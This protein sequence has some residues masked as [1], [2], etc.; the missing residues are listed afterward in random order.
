MKYKKQIATGALALSLLVGGSSVFAATPQDLGIKNSQP[1]YQK[2]NKNIKNVKIKKS[3]NTV[4]TIAS[5]NNTGFIID[6]KNI[7][8]KTTSSIDVKTD[9]STTYT[10]DGIKATASDLAIGQKVIVIGSFDK[11]TNTITAKKVKIVT[12]TIGIN[13]NKKTTS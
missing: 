13:K 11:T 8:L 5:I 7:K 4:G 10:K 9:T 1:T 2:Q 3:N 6:V 12:K